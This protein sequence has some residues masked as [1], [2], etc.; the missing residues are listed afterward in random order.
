MAWASCRDAQHLIG[1]LWT[2]CIWLPARADGDEIIPEELLAVT[3]T[4]L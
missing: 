3:L 4:Q 1:A 2:Q